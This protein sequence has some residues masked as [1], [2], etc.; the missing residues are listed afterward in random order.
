MIHYL[1]DLQRRRHESKRQ[2]LAVLDETWN[3]LYDE[4]QPTTT[5]GLANS[6]ALGAFASTAYHHLGH[7]ASFVN[8]AWHASLDY[9]MLVLQDIKERM[10]TVWEAF[11][12]S[13]PRSS[14][15]RAISENPADVFWG[16]VESIWVGTKGL[17]L[18]DYR[19]EVRKMEALL[20]VDGL[21]RDRMPPQLLFE[22]YHEIPGKRAHLPFIVSCRRRTE[23]IW[24]LVG[25]GRG[26]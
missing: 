9:L 22:N 16:K 23:S 21:L 4:D 18:E 1:G 8:T 10:N 3:L 25:T 19:P 24:D 26:I 5:A 17:D 12:A 20:D 14:N 7:R 2:L 6:V 13:Q 15:E 11:T